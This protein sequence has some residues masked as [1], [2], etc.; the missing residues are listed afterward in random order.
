MRSRE[1]WNRLVILVLGGTLGTALPGCSFGP[2]NPNV[3]NALDMLRIER[4]AAEDQYYSLK[5]R[6]DEALWQIEDLEAQLKK[7]QEQAPAS[8]VSYE[9][10]EDLEMLDEVDAE[11]GLNAYSDQDSEMLTDSNWV[12]PRSVRVSNTRAPVRTAPDSRS[13][14]AP[15]IKAPA[16]DIPAN[17]AAASRN[18]EESEVSSIDIDTLMTRGFDSHGKTGDDGLLVA[19]RP[20]DESGQFVPIAAPVTIS[21]I[22]PA[23]NGIRQRVGLWK[24][25]S[26]QVA[27]RI[28]FDKQVFLFRLPWQRQTPINPDLKLFVRFQ[29]DDGKRESE[30]DIR[31]VLDDTPRSGWTPVGPANDDID[32][33][34]PRIAS[35]PR[36]ESD[37]PAKSG[38]SSPATES[39]IQ[40]ARPEW[41]PIR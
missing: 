40:I 11:A 30:M 21:L 1:F 25:S 4:D 37:E 15:A 2:R 35:V 8:G 34:P 19:I 20:L 9:Q 26:E 12:D 33:S 22:D 6:H 3:Q 38:A 23:R 24:F 18:E 29:A 10:L 14:A 7:I 31:V 17:D 41:S 13:P 32:L 5:Q 28:D 36:S 27:S 16:T 39:S